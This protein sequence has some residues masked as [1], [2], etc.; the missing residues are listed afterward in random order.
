MPNVTT[1][2]IMPAAS[3]LASPSDSLPWDAS[4]ASEPTYTMPITLAAM[5]GVLALTGLLWRSGRLRG[6]TLRAPWCWAVAAII[7]LAMVEIGT[8]ASLSPGDD[9][10]ISLLQYAAAV[11]TFC[12]I[13]ALL[14][15]K[16]PQDRGWQLIVS[17]L[18]ATLMV[19]VFSSLYFAGGKLEVDTIWSWFLVILLVIGLVNTLPTRYWMAGM[20]ATV[21]QFLAIGEFLPLISTW[22][23]SEHLGQL[24]TEGLR[25]PIVL[26]LLATAIASVHLSSLGRS[27]PTADNRSGDTGRLADLSRLWLDFRDDFGTIWGLRIAERINT[28]ATR[29]DWKVTLRWHGFEQWRHEQPTATVTEGDNPAPDEPVDREV[30]GETLRAIESSM[31]VLLRRFVSPEWIDERLDGPTT[32]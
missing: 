18:W 14:G 15:A 27:Q 13:I 9:R 4:V 26:G 28:S 7:L 20:L 5:A 31:R 25:G 21:A 24:N 6:T 23:E 16:R 12:P 3:L 10:G 2:T 19:P 11:A 17:S 29:Y 1:L 30:S 32:S 8:L 22:F